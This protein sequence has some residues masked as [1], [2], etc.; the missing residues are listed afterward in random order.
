M[1]YA[2]LVHQFE[3]FEAALKQLKQTHN[4]KENKS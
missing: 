2:S 1:Q 3:M 4:Q